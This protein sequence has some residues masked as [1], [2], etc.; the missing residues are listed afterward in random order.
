MPKSERIRALVTFIAASV[1]GRGPGERLYL[2]GVS[3]LLSTWPRSEGHG[4]QSAI[5]CMEREL[6][7]DG[8]A[9]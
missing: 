7:D 5:L 8:A 3:S 4:S 9:D 6:A 1:S 2:F